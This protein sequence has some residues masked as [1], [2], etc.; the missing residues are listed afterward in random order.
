MFSLKKL[1]LSPE[2]VKGR[3]ETVNSA[4]YFRRKVSFETWPWTL[5]SL[6]LRHII[7]RE[8]CAAFVAFKAALLVL[9]SSFSSTWD[10]SLQCQVQRV[11]KIVALDGLRQGLLWP[12]PHLQLGSEGELPQPRGSWQWLRLN[13]PGN[14]ANS[15][16]VDVSTTFAEIVFTTWSHL[17]NLF[18]LRHWRRC[19]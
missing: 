4:T 13:R 17:I 19:R 8:P 12:R 11:L 9:V 3:R 14:S 18:F 10:V 6:V 16:V 5:A 15:L 7:G 2:K 1:W